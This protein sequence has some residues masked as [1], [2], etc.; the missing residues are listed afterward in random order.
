MERPFPDPVDGPS[1]GAVGHVRE[2]HAVARQ[3]GHLG[4]A[5]AHRAGADHADQRKSV[6]H[7]F[8]LLPLLYRLG[9]RADL[10]TLPN[11]RGQ[12]VRR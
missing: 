3:R 6:V 12:H 10:P 4:D 7:Q 9:L 2:Q 11:G 5:R 1:G 8:V